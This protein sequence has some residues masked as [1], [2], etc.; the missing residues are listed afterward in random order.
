MS[1]QLK[2][3]M[4][5]ELSRRLDGVKDLLV[6]DVIGI[7][8]NTTVA[9]RKKLRQKNI[10][11]M[12]VRNSLA[13]RATEGTALAGAFEGLA[14]TAAVIWGG[15]DFVSLTKEIVE[16]KKDKT[17]EKFQTR[18]GVMEGERLSPEKVAEISKWPNRTQMLSIL[19]GQILSPGAALASQLIG[20]AG[21]LA[22]QIEQKG[23]EKEGAAE[24]GEAPAS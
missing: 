22:S 19:V 3:L 23:K 11:L 7:D 15:E 1:K 14:G 8:A 9:L 20:P 24:G 16:L 6:V 4:S 2:G 21:K 5:E 10:Q 12:V 18:G 13:R 17:L